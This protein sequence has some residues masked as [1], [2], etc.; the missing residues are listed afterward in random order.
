MSD[1][2][3]AAA[4]SDFVQSISE[5]NFDKA[6]SLCHEDAVWI[7]P[8]GTLTGKA[9]FKQYLTRFSELNREIK[10]T[11]TGI[12]L[13]VQGDAAILEYVFS[14]TAADSMKWEVLAFCVYEFSGEKIKRLTT[15]Y[16]RLPLAK[17]T[18]RGWLARI[19]VNSV[20]SRIEKGLH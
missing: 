8:E 4:V 7:V 1:E 19:A 2:V 17:Q 12:G 18:A 6:L 15:V 10:I 3:I 14:G 20:I 16:D 11:D 5:K 9:E 13:T